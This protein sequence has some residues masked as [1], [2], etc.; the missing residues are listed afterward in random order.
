MTNKA[1]GYLYLASLVLVWGAAYPLTKMASEYASPMVISLFRTG[2]GA[3]LLYPA[4]RRVVISREMV[5]SGLLNMGL[6]LV[7]LNA[8]I[9]LSVNPGLSAVLIY[10]QP[11]FVAAL[12]AAFSRRS[13]PP[14]RMLALTAGFFGALLTAW[15]SFSVGNLLALLGGFSWALGTIYYASKVSERNVTVA[16]ESMTLLSVPLIAALTPLD[17][18]IHLSIKAIAL[19]LLVALLAQVLGFLLWFNALELVDPSLASSILLA[20][21]VMALIFSSLMLGSPLT[22]MD[23]VGVA[24]TLASVASIV[25]MERRKQ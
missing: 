8:S 1:R 14:G 13:P 15:S 2:L 18:S 11:L 10:T 12:Q 19:L 21:P 5:V 3:A 16:N 9:M 25:T 4:A 20:T 17:Y 7:F 24:I 22:H 23:E 6:F